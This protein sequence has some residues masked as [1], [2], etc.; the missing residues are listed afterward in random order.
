M[1]VRLSK[2][3]YEYEYYEGGF[4]E[5]NS[6]LPGR[7]LNCGCLVAT[8]ARIVHVLNECYSNTELAY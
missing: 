1:R 3:Y 4:G 5:G 7:R 2:G 8:Q 6:S